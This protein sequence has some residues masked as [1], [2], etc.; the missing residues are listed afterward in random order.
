MGKS[1][2]W[3]KVFLAALSGTAAT[4][5]ARSGPEG[6]K[7]TLEA[8]RALADEVAYMP[9]PIAESLPVEALGEDTLPSV[10]FAKVQELDA[11]LRGLKA[12]AVRLAHR[13]DESEA[14]GFIHLTGEEGSDED[15]LRALVARVMASGG[16]I[17]RHPETRALVEKA[18][19]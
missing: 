19:P 8:A 18:V 1:E 7:Q 16:L 11:E 9:E 2:L 3:E 14:E 6:V 12:D 4:T 15:G 17:P 13:L 10:L 5:L